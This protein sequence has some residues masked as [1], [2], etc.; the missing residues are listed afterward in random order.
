LILVV[1][2]MVSGNGF[3]LSKGGVF[4]TNFCAEQKIAV[5]HENLSF[6]CYY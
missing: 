2:S 3:W 4:T 1:V 5:E 6:G